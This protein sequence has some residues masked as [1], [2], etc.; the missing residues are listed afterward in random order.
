MNIDYLLSL[1]L[2]DAMAK[3]CEVTTHGWLGYCELHDTRGNT[4]HE[5][6]ARL[7]AEAHEGYYS[8]VGE[9]DP[10]DLVV[11]FPDTA[12]ARVQLHA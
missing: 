10:C 9:G 3:L 5:E 1:L 6:E 11:W 7:V 4:D 12:R 2:I 8:E